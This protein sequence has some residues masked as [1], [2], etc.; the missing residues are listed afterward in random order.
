MTKAWDPVLILVRGASFLGRANYN[1]SNR[2]YVTFTGRY[3]GTSKFRGDNR[4][5]FYPSAAIS[6]RLSEEEFIQ[7][8]GIIH[9]LKLRASYGVAG[10]SAV[11]DFIYSALMKP[12]Y[13]DEGTLRF[14]DVNVLGYTP[15]NFPNS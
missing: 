2:Y 4:W 3:D 10:N 5:Q 6:W 1:F 11:D 8:L 12:I 13:P 14:G 9:R 15:E 7:N